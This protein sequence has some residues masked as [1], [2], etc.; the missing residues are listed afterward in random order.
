MSQRK[1]IDKNVKILEKFYDPLRVR[2]R[3]MPVSRAP[4]IQG[5][6][7]DYYFI[8]AAKLSLKG[9]LPRA[10]EQLKKGLELKQNHLLCRFNQGVLLFK[11]GLIQ[12]ATTDFKLLYSLYSLK[13]PTVC[14][15]LAVCL[16]QQGKY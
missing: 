16:A 10:I 12:E 6:N 13:E 2:L 14:Y 8:E 5:K 15:N 9:D 4:L 7:S 11:L 1:F 3:V